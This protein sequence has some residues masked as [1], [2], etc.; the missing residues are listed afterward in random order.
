FNIVGAGSSAPSSTTASTNITKQD[1]FVVV[2]YLT[3]GTLQS[4]VLPEE[5]PAPSSGNAKLR[6]LNGA[7]AEAGAV[8]IFI[9]AHD[10]TALTGTDTAFATGVSGLQS[11][12]GQLI[13]APSGSTW[14]ICVLATGSRT[15]LRLAIPSVTFTNQEVATLIIT[16][17]P[18]GVL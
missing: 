18:G 16:R 7:A 5:E 4:L 2:S 11:S 17:S 6:I 8:D 10:C 13:T 15:D 1:H 12:F 3:G 14:N 9:T